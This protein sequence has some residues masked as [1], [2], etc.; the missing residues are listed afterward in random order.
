MYLLWRL[1]GSTSSRS[2]GRA[3]VKEC[4]GGEVNKREREREKEIYRK[5]GEV[6]GSA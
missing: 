4:G 1:G 5:K 2:A 6:V 3:K